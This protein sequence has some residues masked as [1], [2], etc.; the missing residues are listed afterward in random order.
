MAKAEESKAVEVLARSG[1]RV[2]RFKARG[3]RYEVKDSIVPGL[4]LRVAADGARTWTLWYRTKGGTASRTTLGTFPETSL[5]DARDLAETKREAVKQGG[6]PQ[7]EV[8]AERA[9][10]KAEKAAPLAGSV[11][12]TVA[13]YLETRRTDLRPVTLR[14]WDRLAARIGEHFGALPVKDLTRVT[15]R[16]WLATLRS[17]FHPTLRDE[18][19]KP[20][21]V[22]GYSANRSLEFLRLALDWAADEGRI[23]ANPA[24][25]LKRPNQKRKQNSDIL[26]RETKRERALS[27]MEVR[28]VLI[29]L[30]E[31]EED[32]HRKGEGGA[33]ADALR[34]ALLTGKRRSGVLGLRRSELSGLDGPEPLWDLAAE[35]EKNGEAHDVPLS[36]EALAIIRRRLEACDTRLDLARTEA[37]AAGAKPHPTIGQFLWATHRDQKATK[38]P[39]WSVPEHPQQWLPQRF[40]KKLKERAAQI[41]GPMKPWTPHALRATFATL[42]DDALKVDH[43]LVS[44]LLNHKLDNAS[45]R[46][47]YNLARKQSERRDALKEWGEKLREWK[48]TE[49]GKVLPMRARA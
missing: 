42:L 6:D 15:V 44:L 13:L 29:A 28:A 16:E 48:E 14:E 40:I 24:A 39:W 22:K 37:K 34:L 7:A 3:K 27:A 26:A 9:R 2:E 32:A 45:T 43:R 8:R 5:A 10:V 17:A 11:G 23:P 30:D 38:E 31:L 46:L 49:P 20:V 33:T 19:E 21:R 25:G 18:N 4:R 35:R 36:P 1:E 12:E 41:H 47:G